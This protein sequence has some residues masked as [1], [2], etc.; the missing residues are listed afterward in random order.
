MLF[1]RNDNLKEN[2]ATWIGEHITCLAY[3]IKSFVPPYSKEQIDVMK[4]PCSQI[5]LMYDMVQRFD[6]PVDYEI[7]DEYERF[8]NL[9]F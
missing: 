5:K 8:S 4:I 7:L 9:T 3:P 1:G 6:I 2:M